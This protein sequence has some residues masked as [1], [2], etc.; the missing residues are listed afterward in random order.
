ME[1]KILAVVFDMDGTL[2]DSERVLLDVWISVARERGHIFSAAVMEKTIGTTA[3]DTIKIMKEA[4]PSA[5]HDEIRAEMSARFREMRERGM[6]GLR[7]GVDEALEIVS[8][9]GLAIGLCTSTRSSSAKVTLE[10]AGINRYFTAAA[11]G[12]EVTRGKPD[13]EPYLLV[14]SK[15]R[16]SPSNCLAV[17]DSPAGA[18]SALSSGMTVAFVPDMIPIPNDLT[19]KVTHLKT[20]A[21]I[22]SLI[23]TKDNAEPV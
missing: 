7:P 14:A 15:L 6:I 22:A 1:S 12:D 20:I 18:R 3:A 5:P 10:A 16:V 21:E 19:N 2:I 11:Y 4:Y 23:K 8:R 13:P 9:A 17:E